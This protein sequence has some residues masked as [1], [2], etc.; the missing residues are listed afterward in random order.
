MG[1]GDAAR[2]FHVSTTSI[3]N[4]E[5]QQLQGRLPSMPIQGQEIHHEEGEHVEYHEQQ[6]VIHS[7]ESEQTVQKLIQQPSSSL[8]AQD[9]TLQSESQS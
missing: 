5:K 3:R 6:P 1:V 9:E 7:T 8:P 4:W 2:K